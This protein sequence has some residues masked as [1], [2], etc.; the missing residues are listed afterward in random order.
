[1][2]PDDQLVVVSPRGEVLPIRRPFQSA[3]FLSVFGQLPLGSSIRGPDISHQNGSIPKEGHFLKLQK[4]VIP[5][6]GADLIPVP[7][8]APNPRT[9]TREFQNLLGLVD[10]PDL[11]HSAVRSHCQI[12]SFIRPLDRRY[13]IL[14][15][16]QI[17]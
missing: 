4:E 2:S 1:M 17:A 8:Q 6:A 15:T 14:F 7:G 12:F 16:T 9:V 5:T 10:I 11:G 13:R 3:D